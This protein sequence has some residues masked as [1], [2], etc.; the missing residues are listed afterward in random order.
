MQAIE[1]PSKIN[2][3][4]HSGTTGTKLSALRADTMR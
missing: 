2:V 3:N 4:N 1:F